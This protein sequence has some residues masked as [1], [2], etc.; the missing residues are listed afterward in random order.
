MATKSARISTQETPHSTAGAH[1]WPRA[2]SG[3]VRCGMAWPGLVRSG[4]VASGLVWSAVRSGLV[5]PRLAWP[6]L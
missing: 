1:S 2:R 6:G 5:W 4:S 3:L